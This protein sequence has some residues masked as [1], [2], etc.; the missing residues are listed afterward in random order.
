MM[1]IALTEQLGIDD[2]AVWNLARSS[3]KRAPL[4]L[5]HSQVYDKTSDFGGT[6]LVSPLH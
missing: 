3:S 5:S 6:W 1:A 4:M 2:I